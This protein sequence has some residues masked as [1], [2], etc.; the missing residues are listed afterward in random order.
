MKVLGAKAHASSGKPFKATEVTWPTASATS[1]SLGRPAQRANAVGVKAGAASAPAGASSDPVWAQAVANSK[2]V[3]AGPAQVQVKVLPH[4][5]ASAVGVSGVVL[6]ASGT[7]STAGLVKLGLDYKAFAQQDGGNF[8]SRLKLVELPAC[9]L[10][11]PTIAACRVQKSVGSVNDQV[12]QSVSAQVA[13]GGSSAETAHTTAAGAKSAAEVQAPSAAMTVLAATTDPGISGGAAGSYAATSLKPSGS[14]SEGGDSGSFDYSYPLTV[15]G[16]S[17]SLTPSFGL[18]YSSQSVDGQ[19]AT[20]N[21]QSSWIGDGWNAPDSFIEQTFGTCSDNPEN[22]TPTP[23]NSDECYDGPILTI[24]LNGSST[25]LVCNAAETACTEQSD[26]GDVVTHVTDSGNGSKTYNTDYWEITERDGTTYYFGLNQLPGYASG[27]HTTNSVDYEPVYSSASGD[28]CYNSA[29]LQQSVCTMAYRWH[30]DYVTN[31]TGQAEAYYYTQASNEYGEFSGATDVSYIRDSYLSEIDYGFAAGGAYGTVPDKIVLTPGG[32]DRC[33]QTSCTALASSSM[34]ATLA[35]TDDP[36]VPFDLLCGGP[37]AE[38]TCTSY[39]PSFFST[40]ML[41]SIETS[42]YSTAASAYEPVDLYTLSQA[43][44]ATGDTTNSTLWLASIQ[45]EGLDTSSASTSGLSMPSETFTGVDLANRVDTANFPGLYRYRMYQITSELGSVT[46][47]AYTTPDTCTDAYV[48]AQTASSG[49]NNTESCYP[50][51]WQPAGYAAQTMDWFESYAVSQVL[52]ADNTGG[53]FTEETDY[54]Y[55]G[56]AAWRYDDNEVV[57]AAYRAYG[58]F[59]GYSSVTT[60]TG[61]VAKNPQTEETTSYYRGMDGDW[62]LASGSTVSATV[63]DSKNGVHTDSDA[64]AGDVLETQQYLGS[65]GPLETDTIESYWVSGSVQT[66]TRTN[67][68][69]LDAQATGLAEVWKSQ[70]D[71]DG[72]ESGASTVTETDTAYDAT[73]TDADFALPTFSYQHTVPVNSAYDSCTQTQ[74]APANTAANLVGLV[75]YTETDK[76]ACSGFTE[77]AD[78]WVPAGSSTLSA[79]S[80]VSAAQVASATETFYDDDPSFSTTFPQTAAPSKG[81][82]TM[83]R[84]AKSG[85]P[86]SFAWQ[87]E[88]RD[89][90]DS[91]GRVQD[92]YDANGNETVTSYTVN[93]VGLTTGE[94]VAAPTTSDVAHTTSETFD[95]T[96]NLTL[97]STDENGFVATESYDALGRLVDVWYSGRPTGDTPNLEYAYTVSDTA[98]SGVTTQTLNNE[99]VPNTSV[100]IDDSLGRVRQTQVPTPQGG[101]LI[102]DTFYDSRGWVLKKNNAYWDSANL[103]SMPT[104]ALPGAADN[105]VPNQDDYVYDGL[106]R[107]V[108]DDSMDDGDLVSTST[109]VYNGDATTV[110][111]PTGGTIQTTETNPLGQTSALVEYSTN[112]VLTTPSNTSTGTWYITPAA[113]STITTSYGYDAAGNQDQIKD[114]AGDIWTSVYN[115][116]GQ[117][118]SSAD[119]DAGATTYSYDANGNLTQTVDA[120]VHDVSY[121]YDALNRKTA[122]YDVTTASQCPAGSTTCTPNPVDTWVY[123]NAN[124]ISGVSDAVGQTTTQTAY[125]GTSAYIE[126]SL[127]FNQLGGSLGTSVTIP[128]ALGTTLGKTWKF[129]NT[130]TGPNALLASTTFPAGGGLLAETTT[131]TYTAGLD[132]PSGLGSSYTDDTY[133]DGTD[134]TAYSQVEQT[135]LGNGT[136]DADIVDQYDPHT[137][138]LTDQQVTRNITTPADVDENAY[139]YSPD[140]QTTSETDTRLGA[141][142]TAETQCFTYTTQNQLSQAWTTATPGA[143]SCATVPTSSSEASVGDPLSAASAYDER[144]SYNTATGE[145]TGETQYSTSSSATETTADT[146]NGNSAA[147]NNSQPTTLTGTSTST[148]GSS[149]ATPTSYGYNA[150][151]EQTSRSTATGSQTLTWNNQGELSGVTN[152]T[153]STDS[154]YIY[155]PSGNL[156]IETDGSDTTLYLPSEQITVNTSSGTTVAADRYYDLPDGA[157]AVR[158]GTGSNYD[159]EIASDQH[160]TNTLYLNSTCQTPTWRQY[161]P[162]GN[163]RGT[164]STWIDNHGFLDKVDDATTAL[165]LIGARWYDP[166]TGSFISLDPVLEA[167]DP[168]QLG[169]YDYSGN[170]PVSSSDPTGDMPGGCTGTT[171]TGNPPPPKQN[172]QNDPSMNGCPSTGHGK[173]TGTGSGSGGDNGD[174]GGGTQLPKTPTGYH[175]EQCS[176]F[177]AANGNGCSP[178]TYY[179]ASNYV[180]PMPS[181]LD[182]AV[183]FAGA[184][185]AAVATFIVVAVACTAGGAVTVGVAC[186][187]AVGGATCAWATQG[188]CGEDASVLED[189]PLA[190]E[191]SA[192]N[193]MNGVN[194]NNQLKSESAASVFDE[195]GELKPEVIAGSSRIINGSDIKN[196]AVRSVLTADGSNM[197]DWGKYTTQTVRGPDGIFGSFQVH[198][199]YNP[200]TSQAGYGIDYKS[201]SNQR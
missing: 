172:C 180:A 80:D 10:T 48:T 108:Q 91:Y 44:Y 69:S 53:S 120:L 22:V 34:T 122:E 89:T 52:V 119:P 50:V 165:T 39:A 147:T 136:D 154:S 198:F 151:G 4:S 155:D 25:S 58:Q 183:D 135:E 97:T 63:T 76:A 78:P 118:T 127:G 36:D 140:G 104:G 192:S 35:G 11:T 21:A 179:L 70:T 130:Y 133:D 67:L 33:V 200:V 54:V 49:E 106:G 132:L 111:P 20:S 168:T 184:L 194:L 144:W 199:Y 178:G 47:V 13:L 124:A 103:P 19:T 92:A 73:T 152:S 74:Y 113:N 95:P 125:S 75:D 2:G 195:S 94:S 112:P 117:K 166:T 68:P 83:V 157:T 30:L 156:L 6:T 72:G 171:C 170:N 41:G 26:D 15:P 107:V 42:Q 160:G 189:D 82:I 197:A 110:I 101:R 105:V 5:T 23:T 121:T 128:A 45:H 139:T 177:M 43:E 173:K 66:R 87:T 163:A 77:G 71:T 143:N 59:R 188:A 145:Q 55:N 65:G 181:L 88:K 161:D 190:G 164:A 46:T 115:L 14:W 60:Y 29:G 191:D 1:L 99:G 12:A 7:S 61:Q 149:T 16:A 138:L 158:T 90:Y 196:P 174:V 146:Y 187:A 56:G 201:V 148:S 176:D 100:T 93:A 175:W 169:G 134:Y 126:Q 153:K 32:T 98:P 96:R 24:S 185:A 18:S 114:Q 182:Q 193:A 38:T 81:E 141:T 150:D 86:G 162:Y 40:V 142:S 64:L 85:A 102:T 129:T 131:P 116:L 84:Q 159:F 79:P 137:G 186:V 51:Y 57:K 17:S 31:T 9:A 8:G 28:P 3:Y 109:T 167:N 123:D 37:Y 27:D 62:S